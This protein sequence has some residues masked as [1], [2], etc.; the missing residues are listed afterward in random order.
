MVDGK[1]VRLGSI[2]ISLITGKFASAGGLGC[3]PVLIWSEQGQK[4][5]WH[6][7]RSKRIPS[8]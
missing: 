6:V 8:S 2:Q 5:L 7:N 3:L 4:V 1:V